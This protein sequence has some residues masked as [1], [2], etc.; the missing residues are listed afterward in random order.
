MRAPVGQWLTRTG[1][2]PCLG[3]WTNPLRSPLPRSKRMKVF[4]LYGVGKPTE[5]AYHF[6]SPVPEN[7]VHDHNEST[8]SESRVEHLADLLTPQTVIANQLSDPD[9]SLHAGVQL[10]DGTSVCFDHVHKAAALIRRL[11]DR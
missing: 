3:R 4:C 1:C 9:T 11:C 6:A 10:G 5:R 8:S 7:E 2:C